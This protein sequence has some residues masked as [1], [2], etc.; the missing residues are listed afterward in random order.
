M[1]VYMCE[2]VWVCGCGCAY[3]EHIFNKKK[4]QFL[5]CVKEFYYAFAYISLYI[6]KLCA[7]ANYVRV[8]CFASLEKRLN[9]QSLQQDSFEI[10]RAKEI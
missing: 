10:A 1:H 7:Q 4:N 2:C 9:P 3:I 5:D 8:I 6:F